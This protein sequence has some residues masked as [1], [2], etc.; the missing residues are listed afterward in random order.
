[1]AAAAASDD[2]VEDDGVDDD[3]DADGGIALTDFF[4]TG[5][6]SD[7]SDSVEIG[8]VTGQGAR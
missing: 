6:V 3:D 4:T 8:V 2:D 5:G 1:M 7:L